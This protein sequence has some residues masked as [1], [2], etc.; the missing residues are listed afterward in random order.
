M[1]LLLALQGN[2]TLPLLEN[3]KKA[4]LEAFFM[5]LFKSPITSQFPNE[6]L[7]KTESKAFQYAA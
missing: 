5:F 2:N 4:S 6:Y 7:L 1:A 3:I